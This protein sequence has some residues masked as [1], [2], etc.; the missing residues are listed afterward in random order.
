MLLSL[1]FVVLRKVAPEPLLIGAILILAA[2]GLWA[3][4]ACDTR[5]DWRGAAAHVELNLREGA[6]VIV[7]SPALGQDDFAWYYEGGLERCDSC[8][9]PKD[10]E[11]ILRVAKT[12]A[13]DTGHFWLI[14]RK[15]FVPGKQL[16][17]SAWLAA[18]LR[19]VERQ[20]FKGV[21]VYLFEATDE[22]HDWGPHQGL[23]VAAISPSLRIQ[24]QECQ[25]KLRASSQAGGT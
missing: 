13:Q 2:P 4:Y 6:S 9:V 23:K 21:L 3:Y 16:N 7:P 24:D 10:Q 20:T 14:L 5:E 8:E 18:G 1:G 17:E 12:C 22:A 19:L 25:S 15:D 11:S